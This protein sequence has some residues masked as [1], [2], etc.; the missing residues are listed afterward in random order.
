MFANQIHA[1]KMAKGKYIASLHDD[2]LWEP[3]FLKKLVPILENNDNFILAFCDQLII[4]SEGNIDT[5]ATERYSKAYQRNLLKEGIYKPFIELGLINKSIPT[6]AACTR[7]RRR[8]G[9][10][11]N[12]L[13]SLRLTSFVA[14]FAKV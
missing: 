2:D 1:L 9:T 4:D 8:N 3:D 6:A 11:I 13:L 5:V 14:K 12:Q 7:P 10:G